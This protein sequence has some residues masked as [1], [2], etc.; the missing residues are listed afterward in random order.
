V[1]ERAVRRLE[2]F[3]AAEANRRLAPL[4]ALKSAV[5][6]GRLKGLARGLAYQI[7]EAGGVIDR[8]GVE[9][10]IKALSIAERRALKALGVRFGAFSLFLPALL[11]PEALRF[12]AAFAD[13]A[14]P[15]WRSRPDGLS[16]LPSPAPPA[17]VLAQRGQRAVA[18][19]SAPVEALER[20]D[21]ALRLAPMQAGGFPLSE[22]ALAGLGWTRAEAV[23]VL[24]GLGF[25][26]ARGDAN[27]EKAL[28]RRR[29]PR[30]NEAAKPSATPAS[31][32]AALASLTPAKPPPPR[33][34]R[35]RAS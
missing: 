22:A 26:P 12:T 1:R 18:G 10:Q 8:R 9:T 11:A 19:L 27:T 21:A 14:A 29:Q 15:T 23:R 25:A 31:P 6:E 17:L 2:A 20:L 16:P 34:R 13:R 24:R 5:A 30:R 3:I 4:R 35:R 28:W 7:L 32:F 33:H